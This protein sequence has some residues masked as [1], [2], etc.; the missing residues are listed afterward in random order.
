MKNLTSKTEI[1]VRFSEVDSMGFVWHGN[2]ALYFE[3]AREKFGKEFS[4]DYL[5]M[6]EQ[7]FYAPLVELKFEYKRPLKLK[8]CAVVEITYRDTKSAKLIF[9]Y[10]IYTPNNEI[11]AT[12]YS[13]QVFLDMNYNLIWELPQFFINWKKTHGITSNE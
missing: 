7:G 13:V 8:D 3:D 10:N 4:L 5:Y 9:D 2:Y 6:F 1:R 12:G 11:V